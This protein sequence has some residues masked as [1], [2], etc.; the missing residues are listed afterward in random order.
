MR[1]ACALVT[2]LLSVDS[3]ASVVPVPVHHSDRG[4]QYASQEYV[5]ALARLTVV[6]SMSRCGNCWDNAVCESF[7]ATLKT[8]L[9]LHSPI[10]CRKMTKGLVFEWIEVFYNRQRL[11]STLGYLSPTVFEQQWFERNCVSTKP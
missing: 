1:F 5:Q 11:H 7:F 10:G 6:Q 4:V 3:F 9:D 2:K 8:E